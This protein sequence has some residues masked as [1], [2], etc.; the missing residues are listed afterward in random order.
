MKLGIGLIGLT[1]IIGQVLL[2]RELVA[3]FYGNE[4]V[5]GLI[6]AFWLL[7]GPVGS[8]GLAR[9]VGRWRLGRVVG[10][11]YGA[12]LVGGCLGAALVSGLFIPVLGLPQTCYAAALLALTGIVLLL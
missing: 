7:W 5:F 11:I 12:D 6:L 8:W 9:I 4:L 2:M 10:L 3:V 1:S